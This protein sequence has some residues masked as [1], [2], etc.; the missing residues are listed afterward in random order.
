L[1]KIL[2]KEDLM[3]TAQ[4]LFLIL[5]LLLLGLSLP[6]QTAKGTE[7][8]ND[9]LEDVQSD[10]GEGS[11]LGVSADHALVN[12]WRPSKFNPRASF[13]VYFGPELVTLLKAGSYQQFS[14]QPGPFTL[15]IQSQTWEILKGTLEAGKTYNVL[16]SVAQGYNRAVA[17]LEMVSAKDP[18]IAELAGAKPRTVDPKSM[19]KYV[20]KYGPQGKTMFTKLQAGK[21]KSREI[22]ASDG[23]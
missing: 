19:V 6:A 4:P 3:K 18:R 12:I 5:A 13:F 20:K 9:A 10:D 23:E 22:L 15:M 2:N 17:R 11:A 7:E 21:A 14:V 8:P 1:G 16:V